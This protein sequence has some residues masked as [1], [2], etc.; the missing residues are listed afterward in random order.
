MAQ[1]AAHAFDDLPRTPNHHFRLHYFA[2]VSH[3]IGQ[4]VATFPTAKVAFEEFPFLIGYREELARRG[5]VGDAAWWRDAIHAWELMATGHLPLRALREAA[6]L[7]ARAL[8]LLFCCGLT[9]EDG[10]FGLLFEALQATPGTH[11]PTMGLLNAWWREPSDVGE[12]RGALRQLRDL[13]L[14]RVVNPDAPRVEWALEPNGP[15]WDA[16]RGEVHESPAPWLRYRAASALA[17]LE[18]LVLPDAVRETVAR[19]PLLLASGQ[20][21]SLIVRGP[22]HGGRRTLVGAVARTLGRGMLEVTDL[23]GEAADERGRAAGTLATLLHAVPALVV[24]PG[25]GETLTLPAL[26]W[27]DGPVA[28]VLGR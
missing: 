8:A 17:P 15:L 1:P 27:A 6:G 13:G 26:A 21:R 19:V 5:T 20:V 14:T 7:D 18:E 22:N 12:V 16:L 2:S 28:V 4:V 3:V 10:R 23:G 24:D 25:P 9:E 11:R